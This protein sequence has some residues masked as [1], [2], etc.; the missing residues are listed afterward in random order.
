M[1]DSKVWKLWKWQEKRKGRNM[2]SSSQNIRCVLI[3][4]FNSSRHPIESKC[5]SMGVMLRPRFFNK[6]ARIFNATILV[7]HKRVWM[8]QSGSLNNTWCLPGPY[9][10]II[11]SLY[12]S[13]MVEQAKRTGQ[14]SRNSFSARKRAWRAW[15]WREKKIR[16]FAFY[17]PSKISET[18]R[19]LFPGPVRAGSL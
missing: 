11:L 2:K 15:P 13:A 8:S 1:Q 6:H 12:V 19:S 3:L 18:P 4:F 10:V 5:L 7:P 14:R 9:L 17:F 16:G